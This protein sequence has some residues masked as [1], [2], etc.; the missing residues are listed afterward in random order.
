MSD[1]PLPPRVPYPM[2][3]INSVT[4]M[5]GTQLANFS[6]IGSGTWPTANLAIFIPFRITA[7]M[8]AKLLWVANGATASGNIDLG[9][10]DVAGTR[11]I[12]KG[13][14]AQSGTSAIQTLD[15][16]D[17]QIGP[18]VFYLA[19]AMD[20]TTGTTARYVPTA[21]TLC[22]FIGAAQMASA[23][24]L[25]ATATFAAASNAYVPIIGLSDKTWT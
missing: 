25:P 20:N 19:M 3:V 15:I 2:P 11:I 4:S 12:N 5:T 13:S 10:Y 7:P 1:W 16:T 18:G 24:A 9:I 6:A 21:V 23:F 8:T 14:T 22:A 17:T